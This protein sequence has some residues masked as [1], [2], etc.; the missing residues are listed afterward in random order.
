MACSRASGSRVRSDQ[1]DEG[2]GCQPDKVDA[3]LV[4]IQP[5]HGPRA[6]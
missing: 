2:T 6:P 5:R 1:P 4:V 3:E